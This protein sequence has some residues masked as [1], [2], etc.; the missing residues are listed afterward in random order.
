MEND[1]NGMYGVNAGGD[2]SSETGSGTQTEV[3]GLYH[4][5]ITGHTI[6]LS[7]TFATN[8]GFLFDLSIYHRAVRIMGCALS[9]YRS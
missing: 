8:V 3:S 2:P 5:S 7:S 9:H 1:S 6:P 4:T